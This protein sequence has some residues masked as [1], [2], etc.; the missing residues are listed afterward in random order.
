MS[1]TAI[2]LFCGC[3]GFSFGFEKA[4]INVVAGIDNDP[5]CIRT[6]EK[7][8]SGKA[9]LYDITKIQDPKK[10]LEEHVGI[11]EVDIVFGS[12]PC[13]TFSNAGVVKLKSLGINPQSDQRYGLWKD[14]IRFVTVLKPSYFVMENVPGFGKTEIP[15]FID[16]ITRKHGYHCRTYILDAVNFGVPQKRKR[17]FICGS[18]NGE[19]SLPVRDENTRINTVWDAISDL[20]E[21]PCGH[22]NDVMEY[23]KKPLSDYQK[24]MRANSKML[25]NHVTKQHSEKNLKIFGSL[26]EGEI[27]SNRCDAFRDRYR[28][29]KWNEPSWTLV[30]QMSKDMNRYIHPSQLRTISV[31]ESA[32][33]QSF[34]DTF[35]F[36]ISMTQALKQIGNAVPPLL[37]EIIARSILK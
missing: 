19:I 32:R 21:I 14:F 26:R 4:G 2:D 24:K 18:K 22:K 10:F 31:R 34:P 12:P 29:L 13:Q 35:I 33:L 16:K 27:Y 8:L 23:D 25:Y 36:P 20:P 6:Y 15:A 1:I 37:S 28:R 11:G 30:A 9:I 5:W 7:N 17:I 3:G